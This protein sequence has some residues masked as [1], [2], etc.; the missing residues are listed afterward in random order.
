MPR[1]PTEPPVLRIEGL[2]EMGKAI[3][4]PQS[5]QP[6]VFIDDFTGEPLPVIK[7]EAKPRPDGPA[8]PDHREIKRK[9]EARDRLEK[10]SMLVRLGLEPG[11]DPIPPEPPKPRRMVELIPKGFRK[12]GE[13]DGKAILFPNASWRRV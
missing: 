2:S 7:P 3:D 9:A 12:I 10:L 1:K 4:R 5:P 8:A 6:D 13:L 11:P